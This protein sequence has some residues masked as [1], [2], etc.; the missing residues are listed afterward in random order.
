MPWFTGSFVLS[1]ADGWR[2]SGGP[3]DAL[4]CDACALRHR[5][6]RHGYTEPSIWV[7]KCWL[8]SAA[9]CIARVMGSTSSPWTWPAW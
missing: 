3:Q 6:S 9:M 2:I 1:R 7:K 5:S 4:C 8:D